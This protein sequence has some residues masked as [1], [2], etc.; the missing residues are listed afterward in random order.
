MACT[1]LVVLVAVVAAAFALPGCR[2]TDVR[3]PGSTETF[4]LAAG[5]RAREYILYVPQSLA[6]AKGR[7]PLVVVLH[8]G[9]GTARGIK[10]ET[11]RSFFGLAE[12]HGFFIA[13]PNSVNKM[14]DFGDEKVS[15]E[16]TERV[17]DRA[18]FDAVLTDAQARQPID[19]NRVFATGISR[20][21][22]ASYYIACEFPGRIRAIAPVAMPLPAFM[23]D[24]CR[25]G[26]P[27]GVAI[28]NGTDDPLVPYDGG[29]VTVG[30]RERGEVLSTDATVAVWQR[31]NG[32]N[33]DSVSNRQ[34]DERRDR[35]HIELFEWR[36]CDGAPVLLYRIAGGGHTWPSG[37][38]YLPRF[39]IG[40][41][42]S[43]IDGAVAAWTFF[44]EFD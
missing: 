26:P 12:Q 10:R 35:S 16:L 11:G 17:D 42:N 15:N 31:R 21:G 19:A 13:F 33:P 9:G 44:S 41:V 1:R 32:C 20:G 39:A 27:V 4:E 29:Q 7:H 23:L 3:A 43:D 22:A 8:G 38:Q 30:R 18:F 37:S 25:T 40:R 6:H 2:P 14:W 24:R 36:D 5:G 34:I 28:M